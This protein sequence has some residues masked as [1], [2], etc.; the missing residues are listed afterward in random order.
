[1]KKIIL[2]PTIAAA[3][4]FFIFSFGQQPFYVGS[5][6]CKIC[7][8][9]EKQG[10][11]FPIWSESKHSQSFVALASEK[12]QAIAQE[13]GLANPQESPKCFE[14]HVP[15]AEKAVELKAEGVT[16]EVCHGPGSAYKT[17]NIMKNKEESVKNGLILY[18]SPEAI[19][20]QCLTCHQ[21]AHGK[22]FD[23]NASW[24][25]IKHTIPE[26]Q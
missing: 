4:I 16:C 9:S 25:K 5:G 8:Q 12:A 2:F 14:C 18:G 10:R 11:Q 17:L 15:L 21:N 7:H 26:K 20:K 3:F 1:M 6:K 19:K 24:E 22:S 13:L 23:F